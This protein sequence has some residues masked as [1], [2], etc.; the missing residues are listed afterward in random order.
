MPEHMRLRG[1]AGV[2][3]AD[4]WMNGIHYQDCLGTSD[5][6]WAERALA[7]L[8][9]RIEGGEHYKNKTIFQD[10]IPGYLEKLSC[11]SGHL[12]VRNS[13]ILDRHLSPFFGR[14]RLAEIKG[15]AFVLYWSWDFNGGWGELV[16]PLTWWHL[17]TGKMRWE[18][19]GDGVR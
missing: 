5:R 6:R 11:R 4:F 13:R 19:I 17:L 1:K 10:L 16:N 12:Q 7:S 9:D 2:F 3:Y 15:P 8:K 14:M 18:R